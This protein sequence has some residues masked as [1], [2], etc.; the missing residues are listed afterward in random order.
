MA[1]NAGFPIRVVLS[2][3]L[4][5]G[6]A[7]LAA[8]ETGPSFEQRVAAL[9]EQLEEKREAHHIPGMSV[10]LVKDDEVVFAR[11]FE[12]DFRAG[13]IDVSESRSKLYG[14]R[15]RKFRVLSTNRKVQPQLIAA[16]WW[17]ATS[18]GGLMMT[19]SPTPTGNTMKDAPRRRPRC[20]LA[21]NIAGAISMCCQG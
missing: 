10:V 7:G 4:L 18:R 8:A 12:P 16:G 20:G 19:P 17:C 2:L 5:A 1:R 9:I 21:P 13:R 6:S 3:I 11:G 15:V 14:G